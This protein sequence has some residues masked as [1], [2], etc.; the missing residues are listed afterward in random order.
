[1]V[2]TGP[3]PPLARMA[4][5]GRLDRYRTPSCPGSSEPWTFHPWQRVVSAS[6]RW[7]EL[8]RRGDVF[9]VHAE[10]LGHSVV[11]QAFL[12]QVDVNP[13]QASQGE[14]NSTSSTGDDAETSLQP[15]A[16]FARCG[17]AAD[18]RLSDRSS[19]QSPLHR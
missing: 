15:L 1:M 19:E 13:Y 5:A 6:E 3:K 8:V 12:E 16:G 2:T 7:L 17:F 14:W 4:R 11:T 10:A 9:A 18:S